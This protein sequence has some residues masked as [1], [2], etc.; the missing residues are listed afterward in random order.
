MVCLAKLPFLPVAA[1]RSVQT[2]FP[3]GLLSSIALRFP[4]FP[5]PS[6]LFG[7]CPYDYLEEDDRVE[8]HVEGRRE[9]GT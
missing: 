7:R 6:I 2:S 4:S 1:S 9:S 8:N 5:Q 3:N